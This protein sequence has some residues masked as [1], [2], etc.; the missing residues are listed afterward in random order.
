M[1]KG[2]TQTLCFMEIELILELEGLGNVMGEG[3]LD[4]TPCGER[5]NLMGV[6]VTV[7][8]QPSVLVR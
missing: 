7:Q 4:P 3:Q 6:E 1:S 8:F 5:K 2:M